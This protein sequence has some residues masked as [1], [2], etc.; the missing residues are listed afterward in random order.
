M[1]VDIR[2]LLSFRFKQRVQCNHLAR[3]SIVNARILTLKRVRGIRME[4]NSTKL[5]GFHT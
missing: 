4:F 3:N 2:R 1:E 5:H